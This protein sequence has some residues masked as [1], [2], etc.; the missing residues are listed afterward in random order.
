MWQST[1][2]CLNETIAVWS[3][4]HVQGHTQTLNLNRLGNRGTPP[5]DTAKKK[6]FAALEQIDP[7]VFVFP[8]TVICVTKGLGNG[9]NAID[10]ECLPTI[11]EGKLIKDNMQTWLRVTYMG[12]CRY[13]ELYGPYLPPIASCSSGTATGFFFLCTVYC[14]ASVPVSCLQDILVRL[15][16]FFL[17]FFICSY[18]LPNLLDYSNL[19]QVWLSRWYDGYISQM[20]RMRQWARSW[21]LYLASKTAVLCQLLLGASLLIS[22]DTSSQINSYV[23]QSHPSCLWQHTKNY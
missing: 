21:E 3:A 16:V 1:V 10:N 20:P 12:I 15:W 18:V 22:L 5:T 4:L 6:Y 14:S 8:S 11:T 2:K 23:F 7:G 17:C 13:L 19:F 9:Y